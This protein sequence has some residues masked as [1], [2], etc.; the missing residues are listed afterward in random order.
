MWATQNNKKTISS[1]TI[2]LRR[3][4][5]EA[6]IISSRNGNAAFYDKYM[7][8]VKGF[9]PTAPT[10]LW[11]SDDNHID[12]LFEDPNDST[13][14]K[15]FH[16][17]KAIV[18]TD[19]FNDM[20]CGYAY[21]ENMSV[22]LVKA[23]YMN[24]MYYMRSL[25][26]YWI[27]P[28][29]VKTDRWA[30]KGLEPFYH[31][32]G[33]YFKTPVGSKNRGYIENFFGSPHWKRCLKIG[34]NNYSGNNMSAK[35]RGVNTDVLDMNIKNRP[36]I[37]S[38]ADDQVEQF[39]Y[40]LRNM[41]LSNGQSKKEQWL[42]AWQSLPVE[43]KRIIT[44][45]QFLLKFGV[46]HNPNNPRTITNRGCEPEINGIQYSYDLP[47][48]IRLMDYVGLK[49]NVVYDPYDMS[50]VLLTDFDKIR[51]IAKDARINSRALADATI[52]SRTYLNAILAEKRDDVD[53]VTSKASKRK[54][55]LLDAGLTAEAILQSGTMDKQLKQYGESYYPTTKQIE[56]RKQAI[57]EWQQK[58]D[59][60]MD[61][62]VNFNEFFKQQ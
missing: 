28:S 45:E 31:Q 40:R 59:E 57:E 10:L 48:N 60:Y 5:N 55:V 43:Q 20:V 18:V 34:A 4:D 8:Q 47:D 12:L 29:E 42:A 1:Q 33:N 38:T 36:L 53:H 19:S 37:G 9:R 35:Y 54:Q 6:Y 41:P 13:T 7:K 49:V 14:H 3:R 11:E 22:E 50:R 46:V 44:D 24:A 15:Y 30:I 32:L 25:T 61:E 2:G 56:E 26:G 17:Y 39:F 52:N 62:N 21:S 27:L 58:D 16:K 51:I 23:A